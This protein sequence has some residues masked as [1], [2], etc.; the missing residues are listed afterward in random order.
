VFSDLDSIDEESDSLGVFALT[1]AESLHE[2]VEFGG[3]LDLEEDFVV[4]IGDLDVEV[5]ATSCRL[6]LCAVWGLFVIRHCGMSE[7]ATVWKL[8]EELL[9]DAFD[10]WLG[11]CRKERK[12]GLQGRDILFKREVQ[13]SPYLV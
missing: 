13:A 1:V 2:L 7:N 6:R 12:R 11:R 4:A 3:S 10:Q 9:L 8:T 5:L